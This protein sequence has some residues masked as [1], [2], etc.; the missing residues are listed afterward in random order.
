VWDTV[1]LDLTPYGRAHTAAVESSPALRAHEMTLLDQAERQL[2]QALADAQATDCEVGASD[3][4]LARLMLM[5]PLISA[6]WLA[7]TRVVV[8]SYR[9]PGEDPAR[10]ASE[11]A[12][13]ID[14]ILCRLETV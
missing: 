2:T 9:S 1:Y 4:R 5:A 11:A 3:S 13:L 8:A 14:Q 6:T 10:M 7:A 12:A